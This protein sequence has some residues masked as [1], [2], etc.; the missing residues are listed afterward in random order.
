MPLHKGCEM[1][2]YFGSLQRQFEKVVTPLDV[3]SFIHE[4]NEQISSDMYKFVSGDIK[5]DLILAIG[6]I[7]FDDLPLRF[8]FIFGKRVAF[9]LVPTNAAHF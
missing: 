7:N 5:F 8:V 1:L 2:L 6:I 3:G 9:L 4:E